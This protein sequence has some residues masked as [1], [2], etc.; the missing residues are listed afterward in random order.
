MTMKPFLVGV[1]LVAV[2][3]STASTSEESVPETALSKIPETTFSET[4]PAEDFD[5]SFVEKR[6]MKAARE[7][8]RKKY[9]A[10]R[11]LERKAKAKARKLRYHARKLR[12]RKLRIKHY[13]RY[14]ARL[15]RMR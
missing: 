3:I 14:Q 6:N 5:A 8:G 12:M 7:K 13:K 15:K 9:I 2:A 11:T 1:V 4:I 10:F